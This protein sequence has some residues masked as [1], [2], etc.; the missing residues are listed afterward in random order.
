MERLLQSIQLFLEKKEKCSFASVISSDN[1]SSYF[2]IVKKWRSS[3]SHENGS[4]L[5][6]VFFLNNE[7]QCELKQIP[8]EVVRLVLFSDEELLGYFA[9]MRTGECK[10]LYGSSKNEYSNLSS[11]GR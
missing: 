9:P 7:G 8:L 1:T 10:L 5:S 2:V 4:I 6:Q 11:F 3:C